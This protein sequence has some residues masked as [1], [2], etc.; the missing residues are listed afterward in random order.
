MF[1]HRTPVPERQVQNLPD[2]AVMDATLKLKTQHCSKTG[3]A[4]WG[5]RG[6]GSSSVISCHQFALVTCCVCAVFSLLST[7]A[8]LFVSLVF[9]Y[10]FSGT[11]VGS[12]CL[13]AASALALLTL[14]LT[15]L[16]CVLQYRRETAPTPS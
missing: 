7:V 14:I 11:L 10:N 4:G 8:L 2:N 13:F 9:V 1:R 6:A 3:P 15:W 12:L 5:S 16:V